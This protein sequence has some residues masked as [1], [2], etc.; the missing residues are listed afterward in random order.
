MG[1]LLGSYHDSVSA[2]DKVLFRG[3]FFF[4]FL[5]NN[6]R[7]TRHCRRVHSLELFCRFHDSARTAD[8]AHGNLCAGP[9][10]CESRG[11]GC[12][13]DAWPQ[14]QSFNRPLR[15]QPLCKPFA[16]NLLGIIC[17]ALAVG[18]GSVVV[19]TLSQVTYSIK[20]KVSKAFR[21]FLTILTNQISVESK[22][23]CPKTLF[24]YFLSSLTYRRTGNSI[25][26]PAHQH[27]TPDLLSRRS[28]RSRQ[29]LPPSRPSTS[30]E[31]RGAGRARICGSARNSLLP[32]RRSVMACSRR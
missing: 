7:I 1:V 24:Y 32:S 9:C 26:G 31:S 10:R 25:L 21:F 27:L 3:P 13:G 11:A 19:H 20:N 29:P 5:L 30:A 18:D 17:T 12:R 23:S 6:P 15:V 4:F 14:A 2:L 16:A 28:T 22:K 8:E